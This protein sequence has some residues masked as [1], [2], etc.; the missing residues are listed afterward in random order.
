M[1]ARQCPY[2]TY[3]REN[4]R[5][6]WGDEKME[7]VKEE[8]IFFNCYSFSVRCWRYRGQPLTST[9][10]QNRAVSS[11]MSSPCDHRFFSNLQYFMSS[12]KEKVF[13][14]S[15]PSSKHAAAE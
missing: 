3:P 1:R 6:G 7:R 12:S 11:I 5:M 14:L 13:V 4:E 15:R 10:P 9:Q 8:I 2:E